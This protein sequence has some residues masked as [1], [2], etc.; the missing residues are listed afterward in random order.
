MAQENEGIEY[1]RTLKQ[2]SQ[3]QPSTAEEPEAAYSTPS[4]PTAAG[5]QVSD[6]FQGPEKRRSPRYKCEGSAQV[7]EDGSVVHTWA[8]F[9]DVSLHGCYIEAQATYP[10]GT[11]L[12]MKLESNGVR[13]E[14]T[15][16]VR[17]SYPYLGMGI[18]FTD[19]TEQA[20]TQLKELLGTVSRP[21]GIVGPGVA[22]AL[23]SSGPM[24]TVPLV[25]NPPAAI[26]ALVDFFET[27]HMLTRE[28]F[29]N[30]LSKSQGVAAAKR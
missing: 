26:R 7:R 16:T 6:R 1:L 25:T 17:V 19:I 4:G 27:R 28:E 8:S 24:D 21:S 22:S 5:T 14:T 3:P 15:G 9:T 11:V 29:L 18:A 2:F 13:L 12:R 20:R 10:V 30:V 23:P